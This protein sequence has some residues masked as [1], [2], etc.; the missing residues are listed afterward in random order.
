VGRHHFAGRGRFLFGE[1]LVDL[2][3]R[4]ERHGLR[5][6]PAGGILTS[7]RMDSLDPAFQTRITLSLPY[8]D[9]TEGGRQKIWE[10]MLHKSGV[11]PPCHHPSEEEEP[12]KQSGG[13]S[14][15]SS[16]LLPID[17]VELAKHPLNGREIKNALRLALALASEEDRPL[18]HELLMETSSMV[19]PI[20]A[21]GKS[22][23]SVD[24]LPLEFP[25]PKPSFLWRF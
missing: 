19:K 9:L 14:S 21:F 20:S 1:A 3:A 15:S 5:D 23:E 12:Q 4:T 24:N 11:F 22:N 16:L 2:L 13:G 8:H 6:A 18:G 25:N 7:N 10:N 17:T